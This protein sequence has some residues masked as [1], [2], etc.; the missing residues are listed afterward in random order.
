[1]GATGCSSSLGIREEFASGQERLVLLQSK[2]Q[3]FWT[4]PELKTVSQRPSW[5]Q[6]KL[7]A[8][9][10]DSPENERKILI[11]LETTSFKKVSVFSGP[12]CAYITLYTRIIGKSINWGDD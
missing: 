12:P 5:R 3:G 6:I 1:M 9:L 10:Y 7:V 8:A 2:V 11:S 4:V